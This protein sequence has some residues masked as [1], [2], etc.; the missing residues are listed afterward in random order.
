MELS[1]IKAWLLQKQRNTHPTTAVSL[2]QVFRS[3]F[4]APAEMEAIRDFSQE[5]AASF[6][7]ILWGSSEAKIARRVSAR[8]PGFLIEC[9]SS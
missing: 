1:N 8:G 4:L 3:G 5:E 6:P 9:V 2:T 7:L